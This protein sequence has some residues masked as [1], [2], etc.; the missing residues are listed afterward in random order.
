[1]PKVPPRP[2]DGVLEFSREE[3][4]VHEPIPFVAL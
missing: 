1:M 2:A 4:A 3:G